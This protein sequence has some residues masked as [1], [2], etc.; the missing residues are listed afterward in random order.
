MKKFNIVAGLLAFA[1]LLAV[2]F[3][4]TFYS[5]GVLLI[6]AGAFI[7]IGPIADRH[8]EKQQEKWINP[9]FHKRPGF[10]LKKTEENVE[11]LL[12]RLIGILPVFYPG[13]KFW[14]NDTGR[15]ILAQKEGDD[16]V[17]TY[18]HEQMYEIVVDLAS[19]YFE[20]TEEMVSPGFPDFQLFQ[21]AL[22]VL[23]RRTASWEA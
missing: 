1:A 13:Y 18:T 8:A 22:E 4:P 2:I 9:L 5:F 20:Y 10:Y 17:H 19:K 15:L 16:E 3:L 12:L 14:M 11:L 21:V 7:I 6:I 23:R